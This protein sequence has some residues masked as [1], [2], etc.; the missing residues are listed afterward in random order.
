MRLEEKVVP[1]QGGDTREVRRSI[2]DQIL[3][4]C[5]IGGVTDRGRELGA[6][7]DGMIEDLTVCPELQIRVGLAQPKKIAHCLLAGLGVPALIA[8]NGEG[9]CAAGGD[10]VKGSIRTDLQRIGAGEGDRK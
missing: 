5:V 1:G 10:G 4:R 8:R 6:G 2:R 9:N 7:G 3:V